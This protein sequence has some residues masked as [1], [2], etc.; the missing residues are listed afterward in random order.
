MEESF[1]FTPIKIDTA[2][3]AIHI[4]ENYVPTI[5]VTNKEIEEVYNENENKTALTMALISELAMELFY[6]KQ[7]LEKTIIEQEETEKQVEHLNEEIE[8]LH[9]QIAEANT[10]AEMLRDELDEY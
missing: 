7:I 9:Y 8:S 5:K 3:F 10:Y 2:S 1:K 4:N 6:A